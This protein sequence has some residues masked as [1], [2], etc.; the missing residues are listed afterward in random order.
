MEAIFLLLELPTKFL[1]E[2]RFSLYDF[3]CYPEY[4]DFFSSTFECR[5]SALKQ[6][7]F[8]ADCIKLLNRSNFKLAD[9]WNWQP[10]MYSPDPGKMCDID[11]KDFIEWCLKVDLV[12]HEATPEK[13]KDFGFSKYNEYRSWAITRNT[14]ELAL[15]LD[16]YP[17]KN[18]LSS[19]LANDKTPFYRM[20]LDNL[21][22]LEP[23]KPGKPS[24]KTLQNYHSEYKNFK[25]KK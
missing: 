16:N 1:I 8:D 10:G 12:R 24:P 3:K 23:D 5:E 18:P 13:T 17:K 7:F 4:E 9:E 21:V 14:V 6:I 11:A 20:L 25:S 22:D 2:T 19:L 15:A